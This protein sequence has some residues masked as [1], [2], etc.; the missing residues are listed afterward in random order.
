MTFIPKPGCR[1]GLI[2]V[3][4]EHLRNSHPA[5]EQSAGGA[6]SDEIRKPC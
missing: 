3:F 5:E 1:E 6:G 4:D 2:N